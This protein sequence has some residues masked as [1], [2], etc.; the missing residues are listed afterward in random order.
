LAD[1]LAIGIQSISAR[2]LITDGNYFRF[3]FIAS[4]YL[5]RPKHRLNYRN[6]WKWIHERCRGSEKRVARSSERCGSS[7]FPRS[8]ERGYPKID[9]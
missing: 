1:P 6:G 9:L 5:P 7:E 2:K 4:Y 8:G 3:Q